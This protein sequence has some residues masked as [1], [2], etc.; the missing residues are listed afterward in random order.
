MY[1]KVRGEL[2]VLSDWFACNRLSLNCDKTEYVDFSKPVLGLSAH[3]HTLSVNGKRIRK[4]SHSK[5]LGV[6]IDNRLSWREHIVAVSR[7]IRQ[8]VGV[9]GRARSFMNGHQLLGLYNTMILPHLQYCLINWGN[10]EGDSN[11]DLARGILSLQKSLVRIVTFS[12][13][14][15]HADPLFAQTGALK[16]DDLY[17]HTLRLFSY[18]LSK[19]H[20]PSGVAS[21]F[22]RPDTQHGYNTRG[23]RDN[24]TYSGQDV[25]SGSIRA[26]VPQS[27][28]SL[29]RTLKNA[30]SV[31]SFKMQSKTGFLSDYAS[32]SCVTRNCRSCR[33]P[34]T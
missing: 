27:W 8:T 33:A 34:L 9:I 19:G 1:R 30:P 18:K 21:M 25:K 2:G 10:F 28:N 5:F 3:N 31:S 23:A 24:F 20:L 14:Y 11:L 4:V 29:Q 12:H 6:Q 7:K 15:A 13:P 32:F 22:P 17:K 26:L 16:I